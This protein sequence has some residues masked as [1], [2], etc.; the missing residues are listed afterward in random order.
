MEI[1]VEILILPLTSCTN[2]SICLSLYNISPLISKV[3][4]IITFF[5]FI[6]FWPHHSAW[7]ILVPQPEINPVPPTVE[8]QNPNPWTAR[9][10]PYNNLFTVL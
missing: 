2:W 8:A 5:I 10:F 3:K 4:V 9:E 6:F 7:G 1:W